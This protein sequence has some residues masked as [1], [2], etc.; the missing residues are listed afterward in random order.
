[1]SERLGLSHVD[2]MSVRYR[3][4]VVFL[5]TKFIIDLSDDVEPMAVG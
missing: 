4:E 3:L 2:Q 1:M 5:S